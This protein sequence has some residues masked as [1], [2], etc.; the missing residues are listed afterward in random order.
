LS[1]YNTNFY[2]RLALGDGVV[3]CGSYARQRRS[4]STSS[5]CRSHQSRDDQMD[6]ILRC[7]KEMMQHMMQSQ[8]YIMSM[9]QVTIFKYAILQFYKKCCLTA[10]LMTSCSKGKLHMMHHLHHHFPITPHQ[11]IY[12]PQTSIAHR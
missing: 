10:Y 9:M 8:P 7:H 5:S 1:V 2:C 3:D 4:T 11:V 12:R 6:D